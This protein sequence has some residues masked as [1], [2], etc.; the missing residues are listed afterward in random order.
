V[1]RLAPLEQELFGDALKCTDVVANCAAWKDGSGAEE[2]SRASKRHN[3]LKTRMIALETQQVLLE[4]L[5]KCRAQKDFNENIALDELEQLRTQERQIAAELAAAE[6]QN[7][8]LATELGQISSK[9]V[10]RIKTY[11][12]RRQALVSTL[13]IL[14]DQLKESKG[15]TKGLTAA[16]I[17]ETLNKEVLE[18]Q[19][20]NEREA[21]LNDT[22][23]DL[24]KRRLDAVQR[25]AAAEA[26][27]QALTVKARESNS[28]KLQS[29]ES[30]LAKQEELELTTE[31]QGMLDG[32]SGI[33]VCDLKASSSTVKVAAEQLVVQLSF[34]PTS[35][36]L[37]NAIVLEEGKPSPLE[38][39]RSLWKNFSTE[40]KARTGKIIHHAVDRN[41]VRFLLREL[42]AATKLSQKLDAE[43]AE[44]VTNYPTTA[45]GRELVITLPD[46]VIATFQ[47]GRD[48]PQAHAQARLV[49]LEVFNGWWSASEMEEIVTTMAEKQK[50]APGALAS[51]RQLV[52]ALLLRFAELKTLKR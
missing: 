15:P 27:L 14:R 40:R 13:N 31:L 49:A 6:A 19:Q 2:L 5:A 25:T 22:C 34:D 39:H 48:Y 33:T 8:G 41:D 42:R 23:A 52:D 17:E 44:L 45:Q 12:E 35:S 28:G 7:A 36:T 50:S 24:E 51:V 26:E 29:D 1:A 32:I 9:V 43:L 20:C 47:L 10:S 38:A 3:E 16:Q 21:E 37:V 11:E 4:R 46:S 18:I 30:L